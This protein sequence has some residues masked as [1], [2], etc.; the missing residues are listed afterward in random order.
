MLILR[1]PAHSQYVTDTDIRRLIEQRFKEISAGEA[2]DTNRHGYMV[3]AEPGDTVELLEQETGC[4][5]TRDVFDETRYGEA[6]FAPS[7]EIL[8]EHDACYEMHF[9]L[10]D[11]GAGYTIFI[12]KAKGIPGGLLA[13]CSEYAVPAAPLNTTP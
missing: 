5:I 2:Y 12:P 7:F 1:D 13:L 4:G 9:D 11:D 10:N 8:E 6:D 3:V